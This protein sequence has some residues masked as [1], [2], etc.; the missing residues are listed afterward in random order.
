M[1]VIQVNAASA[2]AEALGEAILWVVLESKTRCAGGLHLQ[3]EGKREVESLAL[4]TIFWCFFSP[5]WAHSR[6]AFPFLL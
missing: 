2:F 6:F 1:A 3:G 4:S 5:P